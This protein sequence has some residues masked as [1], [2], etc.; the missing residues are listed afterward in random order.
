MLHAFLGRAKVAIMAGQDTTEELTPADLGDLRECISNRWVFS[1]ESRPE[2]IPW[3]ESLDWADF[4]DLE[5][6]QAWA[7]VY[8][9]RA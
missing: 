2:R 6:L 4:Y 1:D 5:I 3:H 9:G 8:A 7:D